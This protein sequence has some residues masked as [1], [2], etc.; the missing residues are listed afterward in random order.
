LKI[1]VAGSVLFSTFPNSPEIFSD[2][3]RFSPIGDRFL[4]GYAESAFLIPVAAHFYLILK[5]FFATLLF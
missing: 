5:F 2:S 4:A 1:L 3:G